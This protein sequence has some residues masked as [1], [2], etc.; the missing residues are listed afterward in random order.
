M[1]HAR[2]N[3]LGKRNVYIKLINLTNRIG[4]LDSWRELFILF[5]MCFKKTSRTFYSL[6]LL[7]NAVICSVMKLLWWLRW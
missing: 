2:A 6:N 1:W 5:W 4:R 3:H 7:F